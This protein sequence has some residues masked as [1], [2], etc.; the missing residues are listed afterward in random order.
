M[1]EEQLVKDEREEAILRNY[2]ELTEESYLQHLLQESKLLGEQRRKVDPSIILMALP[3]L[4]KPEAVREHLL[5]LF[6]HVPALS[7]REL[8]LFFEYLLAHGM[9]ARPKVPLPRPLGGCEGLLVI[10]GELYSKD[11]LVE[12][13]KQVPLYSG[14]STYMLAMGAFSLISGLSPTVRTANGKLIE[15]CFT[16]IRELFEGEDSE[17]RTGIILLALE[18]NLKFAEQLLLIPYCLEMQQVDGIKIS[19]LLIELDRYLK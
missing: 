8:L 7:A 4:E 16:R 17:A 19:L 18:S 2:M 9:A 14:S 15:R 3:T 6:P 1:G 10:L 12:W 13:L 11:F 5:L